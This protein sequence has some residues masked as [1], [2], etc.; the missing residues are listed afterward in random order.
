MLLFSDEN[1]KP[2]K[3]TLHCICKFE[4][5]FSFLISKTW[6]LEILV[7][8]NF[9]YFFKSDGFKIATCSGCSPLTVKPEGQEFLHPGLIGGGT[10]WLMASSVREK[11]NVSTGLPGTKSCRNSVRWGNMYYV[12][13]DCYFVYQYI[14]I[15]NRILAKW[16]QIQFRLAKPRRQLSWAK[17]ITMLNEKRLNDSCFA[18]KTFI[19]SYRTTNKV[20]VI[21]FVISKPKLSEKIVNVIFSQKWNEKM[22]TFCFCF[23]IFTTKSFKCLPASSIGSAS[24]WMTSTNFASLGSS[25]TCSAY[26]SNNGPA[27]SIPEMQISLPTML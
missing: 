7:Y 19:S 6:L 15:S 4:T 1:H 25:L 24:E 11:V 23:A 2:C 27:G 12:R 14:R 8:K 5:N 21:S 22:I 20:N 17:W 3:K 26:L 9:Q 18:L 10:S 13:Y 16:R